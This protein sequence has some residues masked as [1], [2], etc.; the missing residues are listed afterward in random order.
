MLIS[1]MKFTTKLSKAEWIE[2]KSI[3]NPAGLLS[4]QR[5][6][7]LGPGEMSAI[8]LAKELGASPVLLDDHRARKLAKAEGLAGG[9]SR[10]RNASK[11][12]TFRGPC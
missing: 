1:P 5:K 4:A 7:G 3:Q 2:V 11:E 8:F 12:I 10:R 6:Y 9:L